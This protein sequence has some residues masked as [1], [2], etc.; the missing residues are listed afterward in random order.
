VELSTLNNNDVERVNINKLKKYQ[1][2]ETPIIIM[3]V[4]VNIKR[5]IKLV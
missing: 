3:T 2:G 4:V 1:H 5:R